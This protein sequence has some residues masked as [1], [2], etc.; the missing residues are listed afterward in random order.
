[1]KK[2]TIYTDESLAMGEKMNDFLPPPAE[3][4]KREATVKIALEIN[5]SSLAFFK[6][7][8][9]REHVSYQRML[10]NLIDA[11]AKRQVVH[12]E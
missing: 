12:L 1:M 7:Q 5:L 9:E 2:K 11:C 3:L 6:E 10:Q 4:I 8:A